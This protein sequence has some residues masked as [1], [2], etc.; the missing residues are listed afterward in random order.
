MQ[1]EQM[2]IDDQSDQMYLDEEA[3]RALDIVESKRQSNRTG[4]SLYS[5][6]NRCKTVGGRNLLTDWIEHP[7]INIDAISK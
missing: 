2:E 6:L 7:L 4:K 3:I 5:V 1:S